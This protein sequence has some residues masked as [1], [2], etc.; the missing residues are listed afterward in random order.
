MNLISQKC[1]AN[2]EIMK[3]FS[4]TLPW[5]TNEALDLCPILDQFRPE[6]YWEIVSKWI[7][8]YDQ[9]QYKSNVSN[10]CPKE[11][12]CQRSL[13]KIHVQN[14]ESNHK[15]TNGGW[16]RIQMESSNIVT[17]ED[18]FAYDFQS[19]VD[20]VGGTMGLFLGISIYSVVEFLAWV[21]E[22]LSICIKTL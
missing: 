6:H 7:Q 2:Q 10:P 5:M 1:Q 8:L 14:V 3:N 15:S 22:K 18:N 19:L 9:D 13:Y 16:L 11:P 4:C 21:S 20:E 17:I 12:K